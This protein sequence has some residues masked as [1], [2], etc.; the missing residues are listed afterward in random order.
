VRPRSSRSERPSTPRRGEEPVRALP[1][2]AKS[3][4]EHQCYSSS[5]G[6]NKFCSRCGLTRSIDDFNASSEFGRQYWCRDCQKAWYREHRVEHIV[7]VNA[8]TNRY[9]RRNADLVLEYLKTHPCVDCG[10]SD[11]LVLEFDHVRGKTKMICRLKL[12]AA[13]ERLMEEIARCEVRC[14]NCHLKRTAEQ[15]R[16]RKAE[17]TAT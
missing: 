17:R 2:A 15:F 5:N 3:G 9:R 10:E 13:P 1:F 6:K 14:V 12:S 16:W 4:I 11:P 8:N 7:N